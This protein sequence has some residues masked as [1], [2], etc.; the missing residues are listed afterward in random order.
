[1]GDRGPSEYTASSSRGKQ[2]PSATQENIQCKYCGRSH[3]AKSC[4]AYGKQ[5]N[6]YKGWNH[7]AIMHEH[8]TATVDRHV[9]MVNNEQYEDNECLYLGSLFLDVHVHT[10]NDDDWMTK[11]V[12]GR[13][14]IS[15]K[16]DTGAQANVLPMKIFETLTPMVALQPTQTI[17]S[18][19][20]NGVKVKPAG[21]V[22]LQCIPENADVPTS[23]EFFVTNHTNLPVSFSVCRTFEV[24]GLVK[25]YVNCRMRNR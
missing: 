4:P 5:C 14:Q 24:L 3:S 23:I 8:R 9:R 11:M 7:F 13:Q 25:R 16:L 18:A 17:L 20:V 21:T 1:M 6:R 2:G 12:I 22:M 19:F 15:F 10:P